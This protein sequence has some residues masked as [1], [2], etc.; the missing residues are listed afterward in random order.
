MKLDQ[1]LLRIMAIIAG[2]FIIIV[3]VVVIITTINKNKKLERHEFEERVENLARVYYRNN[4]DKLPD[5]GDTVSIPLQHFIDNKSLRH[6]VLKTGETCYGEVEVT[7][8]NGYYLVSPNI[9]CDEEKPIRLHE[10]LTKEENIVTSSHG[11]YKYNDTYI[12]R[13][14]VWNNYIAFA[15]K[16]WAILRINADGTIR[17]MD[18][19]KNIRTVWDN[20]FNLTEQK[21]SGIND[22]IQGDINSRIKDTLEWYYYDDNYLTH[23]EKAYLVPQDLC[24]GKRSLSDYGSDGSIEC[25]EIIPD[26]MLG[27]IQANEFMLASLD[28]HC[29]YPY[30]APCTNYN[31]LSSVANST[32]SITA[33][34]TN[35]FKALRITGG[36]TSTNCTNSVPI[37]MIAHLTNK[38][39]YVSGTGTWNDPYVIK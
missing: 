25:S 15:D 37:K 18:T 38:A 36:I 35:T 6:N 24:V 14:E 2:V 13:G 34:S 20:R 31:Y 7:N 11:L 19:E 16:I 39:I 5:I 12:Y 1:K 33:D 8:N 17:M 27:L 23:E 10:L 29:Y 4:E 3:L 9:T 22:F 21:A 26:Q 32:W 28:E 30:S